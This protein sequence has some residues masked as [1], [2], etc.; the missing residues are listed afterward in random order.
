MK[1]SLAVANQG[2]TLIELI[3][4]ISIIGILAAM[5]MPRFI[6]MQKDAR[7]AKMQGLY[8]TIRSAAMLARAECEVQMSGQRADPPTCHL[9]DTQASIIMEGRK[10]AMAYKYPEAMPLGILAAAQ[11]TFEDDSL[12]RGWGDNASMTLSLIGAADLETCMITYTPA[13]PTFSAT[14]EIVLSGC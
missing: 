10:I 11:L 5:A 13:G 6:A 9:P 12:Q 1:K 2:F 8:G 14:V 3:V 7:I 4:V